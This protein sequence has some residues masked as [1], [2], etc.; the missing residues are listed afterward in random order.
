MIRI[1]DFDNN[2]RYR[3]WCCL[4][5]HGTSRKLRELHSKA[6]DT[7]SQLAN[8]SSGRRELKYALYLPSSAFIFTILGINHVWYNIPSSTGHKLSTTPTMSRFNRQPF[9]LKHRKHNSTHVIHCVRRRRRA[10]SKHVEAAI[11]ATWGTVVLGVAARQEPRHVHVAPC[12]VAMRSA[13]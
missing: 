4:Y 13:P 7:S 11:V 8:F 10:R 9:L 12:A 2:R 6:R 5:S 3:W 1:T